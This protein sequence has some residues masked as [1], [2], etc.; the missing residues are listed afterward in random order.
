[1][2]KIIIILL[3]VFSISCTTNEKSELMIGTWKINGDKDYYSEV[4]I[5][6]NKVIVL[7]TPESDLRIFKSILKND[8]LIIEN[9]DYKPKIDSFKLICSSS[10]KIIL[11]RKYLNQLLEFDKI[12]NQISD[13]DSL[14][15]KS[16]K[17]KTI[18][19]FNERASFYFKSNNIKI[20]EIPDLGDI[21]LPED[22]QLEID[23]LK[24]SPEKK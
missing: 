24:L 21:H 9:G 16:W 22:I 11:R 19:D 13:I 7:S 8:Y 3:T 23:S 2:K 4:K 1:M 12:E 10:D 6:K 18:S 15:L 20:P 17:E 14:K 5:D